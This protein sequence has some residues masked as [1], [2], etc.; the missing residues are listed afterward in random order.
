[1]QSGYVWEK[2]MLPWVVPIEIFGAILLLICP[3]GGMVD[4]QDLVL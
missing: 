3:S 2:N 4:T 1:M